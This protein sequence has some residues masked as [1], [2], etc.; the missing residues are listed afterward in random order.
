MPTPTTRAHASVRLEATVAAATTASKLTTTTPGRRVAIEQNGQGFFW[1]MASS[2]HGV[3]SGSGNYPTL[4]VK[5]G[6]TV[7]FTGKTGASHSFAVV[8]SQGNTVVGPTADGQAF[9]VTWVAGSAGVFKYHCPAHTFFM[10][11]VLTVVAVHE[12]TAEAPTTTS[13]P[14]T[15]TTIATHAPGTPLEH[16]VPFEATWCESEC[17]QQHLRSGC[18]EVLAADCFLNVCSECQA[19]GMVSAAC[20]G[21]C[22]GCAGVAACAPCYIG[23]LD[24]GGEGMSIPEKYDVL[25]GGADGFGLGLGR[26]LS[27]AASSKATTPSSSPGT[28][29]VGMSCTGKPYTIQNIKTAGVRRT[30][31]DLLSFSL[32]SSHL[33]LFGSFQLPGAFLPV[34]GCACRCT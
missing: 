29:A 5:V 26:V 10:Q 34:N 9:S 14:T 32:P 30:L 7:I 19:S 21:Q 1:T 3:V 28:A 16:V 13:V 18:G 6:D 22:A 27:T 8:G 4:T 33:F 25:T 24:G 20:G 2:T 15:T 31:V 12:P 17:T 23:C 11:G